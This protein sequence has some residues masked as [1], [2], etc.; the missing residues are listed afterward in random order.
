MVQSTGA[1]RWE[2]E[3]ELDTRAV[4]DRGEWWRLGTSLYLHADFGHVIANVISG[5]FTFSAVVSTLGRRRG[6]LLVALAALTGNLAVA[7]L[8]YPDPH[9]SLGASTAIF[10]GLGLLTGRAV[11]VVRQAARRGR[12]SAV[13]VPMAAGLTLL[14][15]FGAGGQEVDVGAH[16]TGFAA[17]LAFGFA[18]GGLPD[19]AGGG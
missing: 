19:P 2:R 10:A 9:F 6:W 16:L 1:G 11:R 18:A 12:W 17:G 15:L 3:G 4:F 14:G 7:A 5:I 13:L 8:Y